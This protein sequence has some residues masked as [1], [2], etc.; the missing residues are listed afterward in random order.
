M[1][2]TKLKPGTIV[3]RKFGG[4][5]RICLITLLGGM[6]NDLASTSRNCNDVEWVPSEPSWKIIPKEDLILYTHWPYK[7][8]SFFEILSNL[9]MEQVLARARARMAFFKKK[10]WPWE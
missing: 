10:P 9:D 8:K 3:I 5:K 1:E 2:I 6:S 7:T 4:I